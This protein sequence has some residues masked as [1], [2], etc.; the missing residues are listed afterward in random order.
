MPRLQAIDTDKLTAEQR[1][2]Y[3]AIASGWYMPRTGQLR[4]FTALS[5]SDASSP[6]VLMMP[7]TTSSGT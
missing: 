2:V 4:I 6:L 1:K 7:T 5:R 3:D